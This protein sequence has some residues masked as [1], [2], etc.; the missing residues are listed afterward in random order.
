MIRAASWVDFPVPEV[1]GP[2]LAAARDAGDVPA[3][4]MAAAP[5]VGGD[6]LRRLAACWQMSFITGASLAALVERVEA[7]LRAAQAHRQEVAAQL[8]GPRATARLLAALPLL[9]LLLAAG[10]GMN[11]LAFLFGGPAGLGC[12]VLGL[13]LDA[14]GLWWTHR[15]AARAESS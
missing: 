8:A 10:L 14:C 5:E 15:L 2:V 7:A 3:A 13:S 6:G 4:L 11:P 9:G 12:L 1:M